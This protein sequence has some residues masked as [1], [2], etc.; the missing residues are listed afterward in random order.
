MCS[1]SAARTISGKWL[2]PVRAVR[3]PRSITTAASKYCD[4]QD[5]PGHVCHVNGDCTRFL[6]LWN[7]VFMQYNRLGPDKLEPLPATHVDTG[8]G[9]ERIV[10]VLQDVNSNYKT[11]LFTKSLDVLRSLTGHT[12]KQMLADFTPYRVIADH[13]RSAAFLIAD[14]VVPGNVGRN[15]VCR[16]IIRRAA[17]FGTKIGLN[18]PFLA[19]WPRR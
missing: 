17:R 3:A 8:M 15:Y 14:G 4:K 7:L 2:R 10:S 18:E 16:M 19:K 13:T 6:E 11:D 1:T 12:E 5:V 9:F